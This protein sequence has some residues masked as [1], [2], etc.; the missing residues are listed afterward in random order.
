MEGLPGPAVTYN[1]LLIEVADLAPSDEWVGG[2]LPQDIARQ[3]HAYPLDLSL[4]TASLERLPGVWRQ[5]RSSRN[6]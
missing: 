6:E 1:G 2:F 3:I 4:V 5:L